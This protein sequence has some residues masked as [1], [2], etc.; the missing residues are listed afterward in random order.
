MN[1]PLTG[2]VRLTHGTRSTVTMA[3]LVAVHG[4]REATTVEGWSLPTRLLSIKSP[5]STADRQLTLLLEQEPDL[6]LEFDGAPDMDTPTG[7]ESNGHLHQS[8][9]LALDHPGTKRYAP[10]LI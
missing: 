8:T 4:L 1:L 10:S 9:N 2:R 5:N 7:R 6:V 3:R